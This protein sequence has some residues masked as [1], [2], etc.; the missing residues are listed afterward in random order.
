MAED[1]ERQ[2]PKND[3]INGSEQ[4]IARIQMAIQ[5]D[6]L[7]TIK[8]WRLMFYWDVILLVFCVVAVAVDP[9]FLYLPVINE[10]TKCITMDST[11]QIMFI[12]VRS[13]MDLVAWCMFAAGPRARK[14]Y[15]TWV[16]HVINTLSV[17]PVAQVLVP[18][19]SK[20]NGSKLRIL[21][22]FLNATV[23]LQYVPRILRI[24]RLW[25]LIVNETII[26]RTHKIIP[27]NSVEVNAESNKN[28][29]PLKGFIVMKAGFNLLLYLVASHVR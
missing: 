13:S 20:M 19:I 18:R 10:A 12:C 16:D 1:I 7:M 26:R 11:L 22:K 25:I 24:Y 8:Y 4:E 15:Y 23:L 9:L 3:G 5:D 14:G 17:L 2:V 28:T 21:R 6:H 29:I 27:N